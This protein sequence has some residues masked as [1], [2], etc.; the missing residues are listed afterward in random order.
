MNKKEVHA[1]DLSQFHGDCELDREGKMSGIYLIPNGG[2]CRYSLSMQKI[3]SDYPVRGSLSLLDPATG[4][5]MKVR[6][7]RK[8]SEANSDP[9]AD[10]KKEATKVDA[11]IA[12]YSASAD[13]EDLRQLVADKARQLYNKYSLLMLDSTKKNVPLE[14]MTFSTAV[15]I[16]GQEYICHETQSADAQHNRNLRLIKVS[17]FISNTPISGLS[18]NN[19]KDV[20]KKIGGNWRPYINEAK[21]FVDYA[22]RLTHNSPDVNIFRDYL[23]RHP[24][25]PKDNVSDFQKN[26]ANSDILSADEEST[27]NQLILANIDNG[28]LIGITLIK[29]GGLKTV[30]A[31]ELCW[32]DISY[33]EQF[34]DFVLVDFHRENV[35]GATHDYSFLMFPFGSAVLKER[36]AWLQQ[37]GYSEEDIESMPVASADGNPCEKLEP[38]KLSNFCRAILHSAGA[39]YAKLAAQHDKEIGGG[40]KLL[41]NTYAYRLN[42]VCNLR[43]DPGVV[44]FMQ[45]KSLYNMLQANNY[46]SFTDPIARHYIATALRRDTFRLAPQKQ[47]KN[48]VRSKKLDSG[49]EVRVV[50]NS[51]Q[52]KTSFLVKIRCK[53][54]HPVEI[55]SKLGC[56]IAFVD[57]LDHEAS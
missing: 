49:K 18:L 14:Q 34:P 32:E 41:L 13:G 25:K 33:P 30:E 10:S 39:G 38:G 44:A 9:I 53:T 20:C 29:E 22:L 52:E 23:E 4:Q 19:V 54:G 56:R 46:R 26:A 5:V 16:Y 40:V 7:D 42:D 45:H 35:S 37:Q 27:L 57:S 24:E 12:L 3:G 2:S 55:E 51:P 28:I 8:H 31:C 47:R 15:N 36:R 11:R 6:K 50:S 21:K 1:E 43:N 48:T 17:G